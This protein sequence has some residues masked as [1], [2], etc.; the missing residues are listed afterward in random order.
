MVRNLDSLGRFVIPKEYRKILGLGDGSNVSMVI[1]NGRIIIAPFIENNVSAVGVVR[2]MDSLGR[3]TIP[4]EYKK[5]LGMANRKPVSATIE[6]DRVVIYPFEESLSILSITIDK[7]VNN[8][9]NDIT[10]NTLNKTEVVELLKKAKKLL[11][12]GAE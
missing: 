11:S 12:K 4:G 10:D 6:D 2:K 1:E 3:V 5:V 7:M 8:I 9:I